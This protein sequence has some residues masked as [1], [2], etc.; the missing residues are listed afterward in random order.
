MTPHY[1]KLL[2]PVF[3]RILATKKKSGNAEIV[4]NLIKHGADVNVLNREGN[5]PLHFAAAQGKKAVVEK[6]LKLGIFR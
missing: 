2:K 4:E 1:T 5:Y 3:F 6:L